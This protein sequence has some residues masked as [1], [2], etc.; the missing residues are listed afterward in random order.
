MLMCEM[1]RATCKAGHL[2]KC[3][4]MITRQL[5]CNSCHADRR[6][7]VRAI[8]RDREGWAEWKELRRKQLRRKNSG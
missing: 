8:R 5:L 2:A 1:C 7:R 3:P 4:V 6:H